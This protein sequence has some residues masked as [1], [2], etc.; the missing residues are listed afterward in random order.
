MEQIA[1]IIGAMLNA[2]YSVIGNFGWSIILLSLIIKVL[3]LPLEIKGR[4]TNIKTSKI[5]DKQKIIQEKYKNN[6]QA[7]NQA[8]IDLYKEEGMSPMA[9]LGGCL[10]VIIQLLVM[11]G[12]II[13][14]VS[15]LKYIKGLTTE[16]IDS[17]YSQ[18]VEAR[19]AKLTSEG[20]SEEEAKTEAQKDIRQKEMVIIREL[21][22][23]DEKVNINMEFLGLDLTSIP[24]ETIKSISDL[25]EPKNLGII[26]IPI[27][28]IVMSFISF[29]VAQKDMEHMRQQSKNKDDNVVKVIE[30]KK[31][32]EDEEK[33]TGEDFQDAMMT[34]NKMMKYILPVMIF[35]V[36]MVTSLG[37]SIYWAFNSMVDILK[38]YLLKHIVNKKLEK[39]AKGKV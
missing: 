11:I 28:Y 18:I 37:I 36:S 3:L 25:K 31:E 30:D 10:M 15:P 6:Q 14:V 9:P 35:S 5:A 17:K 19:V 1:T 26:S 34:S 38:I 39:D 33:F 20:K 23:T 8:M 27:L 4:I 13:V 12:I 29:G 24:S 21:G 2:I 32:N 7:F 16:E 22:S